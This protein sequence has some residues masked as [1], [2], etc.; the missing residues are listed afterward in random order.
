MV[1]VNIINPRLLAD[2][3]LVAEYYEI[4]ML[5]SYVRNY[6][7]LEGIPAD[8]CLGKGHIK[9]FKNKLMYLKK[10]HEEIKKEMRRRGFAARM[11]LNLKGFG[12]AHKNDWKAC[13]RDKKIIK[14]RIASRIKMKPLFYRYYGNKV[15]R[16]FLTELLS[17]N[18]V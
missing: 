6:P 9:F 8:Y 4:I 13:E 2:Q 1:R 7:C 18:K 17:S 12:K 11:T 10:R 3:H 15:G 14:S 5:V 16:R